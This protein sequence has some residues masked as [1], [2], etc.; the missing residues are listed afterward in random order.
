MDDDKNDKIYFYIQAQ[1][2]IEQPKKALLYVVL[3]PCGPYFAAGFES[4]KLL[5]DP[6][7]VRAWPGG[8]GSFKL[9]AN[10]A[11]TLAIQVFKL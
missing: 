7:F 2:K 4:I 3:S 8:S 6:Q 9:G 11:P 1:L 10:Y 5:A